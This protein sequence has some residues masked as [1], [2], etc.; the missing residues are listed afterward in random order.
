MGVGVHFSL[1]AG[2]HLNPCR[3]CV[4]LHS[5][6]EF[7]C[8]SVLLPKEV[9]VLWCLPPSF[10]LLCTVPWPTRGEIWWNNSLMT[11]WSSFSLFLHCP[12]VGL[13][14]ISANCS[15]KF[16]DD[17]YNRM[18]LKV[19]WLLWSYNSIWF[20]PRSPAYSIDSSSWPPKECQTSP[21]VGLKSNQVSVCYFH[22]VKR[23]LPCA[24]ISCRQFTTVDHIICDWCSSSS[25]GSEHDTFQYREH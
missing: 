22:N 9:I 18:S 21:W 16:S 14:L 8:V 19:I 4:W 13:V 7:L 25:L 11:E 6:C 3:S 5:I 17:W 10:W 15:C 2:T 20:S 23:L 24:S 1:D 12:I